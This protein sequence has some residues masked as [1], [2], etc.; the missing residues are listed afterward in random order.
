L[1]AEGSVAMSGSPQQAAEYLKAEHQRWG[2]V[3]RDSNVKVD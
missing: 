2:A 1:S 3:V